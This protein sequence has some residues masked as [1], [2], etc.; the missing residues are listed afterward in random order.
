[1]SENIGKIAQVIGPVVDVIFEGEGNAVPPIYTSLSV[2]REDGSELILE[3]EQHAEVKA[4]AQKHQ[5]QAQRL[6]FAAQHQLAEGIVDQNARHDDR[7][8]AGIVVAV[9]DEGR[10]H[11]KQLVERNALG[12]P[13]QQEIH[14]QR[15]RQKRQNEDIGIKQHMLFSL[16]E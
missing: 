8:I 2:K 12:Q 10:Q 13:A 6:L 5:R 11:Q 1:M 4:E 15:Q 9:E 7:H 3:V 16:Q 14:K